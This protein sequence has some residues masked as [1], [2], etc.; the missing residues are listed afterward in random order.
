MTKSEDRTH[1]SRRRVV[2]RSRGRPPK[3]EE[4][5]TVRELALAYQ[6]VWGQGPQRARDLALAWLEGVP[7][8]PSKLPRGYRKAAA[9]STL[10]GF[11]LPHATFEGREGAIAKN[12]RGGGVRRDVVLAWVDVLRARDEKDLI[13]CLKALVDA[14][15]AWL[16]R[17]ITP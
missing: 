17:H 3:D 9:R 8:R 12:R 15:S 14:L 6:L 16:N 1:H 11:V 4:D 7:D 13:R 10:G 2:R 5:L